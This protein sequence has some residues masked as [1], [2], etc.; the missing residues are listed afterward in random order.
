MLQAHLKAGRGR[1]GWLLADRGYTLTTYM[2]TL[3]CLDKVV[4]LSEEPYQKKNM[5]ER[6]FVIQKQRFSCLDL[7]DGITQ[8]YP[9]C[10]CKIVEATAVLQNMCIF[11]EQNYQRTQLV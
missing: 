10:F 11:E 1:N 9:S 2:M 8:F 3:F 7:S 5:A 4:T 6:C